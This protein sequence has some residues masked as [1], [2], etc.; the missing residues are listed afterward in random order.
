MAPAPKTL[1]T[2]AE[3]LVRDRPWRFIGGQVSQIRTFAPR[4]TA[5][6]GVAP[7]SLLGAVGREETRLEWC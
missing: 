2:H 1:K 5:G 6:P 4:A 3:P 7:G